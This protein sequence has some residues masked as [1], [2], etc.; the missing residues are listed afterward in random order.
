MDFKIKKHA[1]G[2]FK[3]TV[4]KQ[5]YAFDKEY[6]VFCDLYFKDQFRDVKRF[7]KMEEWEGINTCEISMKA[8]LETFEIVLEIVEDRKYYDVNGLKNIINEIKN[9]EE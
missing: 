4:S 7:L 9:V 2:L 6:E 8:S 5:P 1:K 3:V